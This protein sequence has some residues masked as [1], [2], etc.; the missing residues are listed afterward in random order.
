MSETPEKDG[1][2]SRR[3]SASRYDGKPCRAWARRGPDGQPLFDPPLCFWH[4][5]PEDEDDQERSGP[6]QAPE[7]P[8]TAI[9]ISP[10][11]GE[12]LYAPFF[13]DADLAALEAIAEPNSLRGEIMLVRGFMR[14][15]TADAHAHGPLT[16]HRLERR[17][18]IIFAGTDTLSRVLQVERRLEIGPDGVPLPIAEAL[19]EIGEEWG[20]DL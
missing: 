5:P 6:H 19:D 17:A 11:R 1:T 4:A 7:Q 12:A 14:W 20:I 15:L 9:V 10:D 16:G 18:A 8:N 2:E 13:E 3:C